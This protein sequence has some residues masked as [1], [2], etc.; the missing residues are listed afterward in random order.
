M[1]V[2]NFI[3]SMWLGN[4]G[5]WLVSWTVSI[6][7]WASSYEILGFFLTS[8]FTPVSHMTSGLQWKRHIVIFETSDLLDDVVELSSIERGSSD[9][10]KNERS[11]R[12]ELRLPQLMAT[13][14]QPCFSP[15]YNAKAFRPGQRLPLAGFLGVKMTRQTAQSVRASWLRLI[16]SVIPILN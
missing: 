3:I 6:T 12:R 5:M 1:W 4:W 9:W 8:P 16:A 14:R 2:S 10:L 11:W 13:Q 15:L 7:S